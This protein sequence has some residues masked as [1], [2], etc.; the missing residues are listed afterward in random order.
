MRVLPFAES[1][2]KLV[3]PPADTD[4]IIVE[5]QK[6]FIAPL[7]NSDLLLDVEPLN[8]TAYKMLL[9]HPAILPVLLLI[10][11]LNT[12]SFAT[13]EPFHLTKNG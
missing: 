8:F 7:L 13:I 6:K 2:L 11:P 10:S 1:M 4:P 5:P 9:V 12:P 3:D